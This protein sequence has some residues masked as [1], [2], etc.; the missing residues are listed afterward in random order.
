[1]PGVPEA[2]TFAP[3]LSVVMPTYNNEPVL[4]RAIDGWRRYGG[5]RVEL[6]VIEDGCRD[7]TAAYLDQV[8][9][10]PWGTRRL[11]AGRCS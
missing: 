7:G 3:A 5:D 9:A 6:I 8:A 1:M 2:L 4:R 11:R 10:T